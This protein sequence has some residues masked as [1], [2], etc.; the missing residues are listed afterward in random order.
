MSYVLTVE[1]AI[2]IAWMF[3]HTYQ[4]SSF[5]PMLLLFIP[6]AIYTT[7]YAY[8]LVDT[9]VITSETGIEYR[10]P[11]GS[12]TAPWAQI[13]S[14]RRNVVLPGL[15]LRYYLI[16]EAPAISYSKWFGTAY[17]LQLGQIL[18]PSKQKRIP[19]GK[20]WQ[21]YEELEN[22]LRAHAPSLPFDVP[23]NR[24]AG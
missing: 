16:L 11:E 8:A 7:T 15:G 24:N 5:A 17:K 4:D 20:M 6:V 12:I 2:A 14:L 23:K 22:E 1:Y 10:R 19:L 18:F 3:Y 21:G 9:C 13:K